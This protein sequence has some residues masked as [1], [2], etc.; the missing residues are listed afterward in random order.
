M[1]PRARSRHSRRGGGVLGYGG[2]RVIALMGGFSISD[3]FF[4]KAN[5]GLVVLEFKR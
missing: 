4:E 2:G 1:K 3:L 5:L